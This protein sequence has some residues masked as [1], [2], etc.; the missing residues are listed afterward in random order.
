MPQLWLRGRGCF[1][2]EENGKVPL[3]SHVFSLKHTDLKQTGQFNETRSQFYFTC[4]HLPSQFDSSVQEGS[5]YLLADL[6][7]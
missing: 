3:S 6:A 1:L 7:L 4:F 5:L 2:W